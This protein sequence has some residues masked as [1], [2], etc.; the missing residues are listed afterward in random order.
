MVVGI[1]GVTSDSFA[2]LKKSIEDLT[3]QQKVTAENNAISYSET[4]GLSISPS[5]AAEAATAQYAAQITHTNE[6]IDSAKTIV[7]DLAEA[8]KLVSAL[9][10][11][12]HALTSIS[13][14]SST[15]TATLDSALQPSLSIKPSSNAAAGVHPIE[16][17]KVAATQ[18]W[19][20]E[21]LGGYATST[22]QVIKHFSSATESVCFLSHPNIAAAANPGF[23]LQDQDEAGFDVSWKRSN[24]A[25]RITAAEVQAGPVTLQDI[26][27]KINAAVNAPGVMIPVTARVEGFGA[28]KFRIVI[29]SN[30][31]GIDNSFQIHPISI[32]IPAV[33]P[34]A[35]V[36]GSPAAILSSF[37]QIFSHPFVDKDGGDVVS[38]KIFKD[39]QNSQW[40]T[41][42]TSFD[43]IMEYPITINGSSFN[44]E[45]YQGT[46]NF[47]VLSKLA[48]LITAHAYETGV[49]AMVEKT[50]IPQGDT[51]YLSLR[52]QDDLPGRI[53]VKLPVDEEGYG[54][55]DIRSLV[56]TG[57]AHDALVKMDGNI[58][59][60]PSNA[61]TTATVPKPPSWVSSMNITGTGSGKVSVGKMGRL[62]TDIL[63][64]VDSMND[65]IKFVEEHRQLDD[66]GQPVSDLCYSTVLTQIDTILASI[67]GGT[68][69][70]GGVGDG[71]IQTLEDIGI[72]RAQAGAKY[73]LIDESVFKPIV[74]NPLMTEQVQGL[75][76]PYFNAVPRG[77]IPPSVGTIA[78][79]RASMDGAIEVGPSN[80]YPAAF[81]NINLVGRNAGVV[82]D[83]IITHLNGTVLSSVNGQINVADDAAHNRYIITNTNG[84]ELIYT[85]Q[86]YQL[87][88]PNIEDLGVTYTPPI[89]GELA[90][91]LPV[92]NGGLLNPVATSVFIGSDNKYS[93][94]IQR[95]QIQKDA[96]GLL[97]ATV[98][99]A[100]GYSIPAVTAVENGTAYTISTNDGT[101]LRLFVSAVPG[102]VN[103]ESVSFDVDY[104][105]PVRT[106]DGSALSLTTLSNSTFNISS[107]PVRVLRL[108]VGGYSAYAMYNNAQVPF[109]VSDVHG[110]G[111]LLTLRGDANSVFAGITMQYTAPTALVMG[112]DN[113]FNITF[114]RGNFNLTTDALINLADPSLG[115]LSLSM[116]TERSK[117]DS[118]NNSL[119]KVTDARSKESL[120]AQYRAAVFKM[121]QDALDKM[122]ERILDTL[123][124]NRK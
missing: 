12:M 28:S 105:P 38:V 13:S 89:N 45:N 118:L 100:N 98:L 73:L 50:R 53:D 42:G 52:R 20:L 113:E 2:A 79:V 49:V 4:D 122:M 71:S 120:A 48:D 124:G 39:S 25:V 106:H 87:N 7:A 11:S 69:V 3:T 110:D 72:T 83:V 22:R 96:A 27:D 55:F 91:Q 41:A 54:I 107:F 32:D 86:A 117:L 88:N 1:N 121:Q 35:G 43:H 94:S 60:F 67:I 111:T 9:S 108:A 115:L 51:C 97:T 19:Y 8:S 77:H 92:R 36:P 90:P 21:G 37:E 15:T 93:G 66:K 81:N 78:L 123:S 6:R 59:E 109:I 74:S 85:P 30:D 56:Y 57:A 70:P 95:V 46:D 40:P 101:K 26:V 119:L 58:F 112:Q 64:F 116:S 47:E 76:R 10:S 104:T 99:D 33:P 34:A 102:L 82:P 17:I 103:G 29:E 23:Y 24:A 16:V 65:M 114:S 5:V 63:A 14:I 31:T 68:R 44:L 62:G 61:I 18:K 80:T 75:F 84:L